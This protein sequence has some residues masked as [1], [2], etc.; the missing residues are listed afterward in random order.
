MLAA[1]SRVRLVDPTCTSAPSV[2]NSDN[3]YNSCMVG[4]LFATHW[5]LS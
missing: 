1:N 4:N 3:M 5:G 2:R